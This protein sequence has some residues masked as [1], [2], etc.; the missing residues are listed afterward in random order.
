MSKVAFQRAFQ[1]LSEAEI[2]DVMA[3][4]ERINFP[5]GTHI[6]REGDQNNAIFVVLEGAIRVACFDRGGEEHALGVSLGP[7]DTFGE[8]SFVDGMGASATLIAD[9][10]VLTQVIDRAQIDAMA[11]YRDGFKERI[12]HSLLYT[13]VRRLR[14]M[15]ALLLVQARPSSARR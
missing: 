10:D 6:L 12:Y 7:G 11:A 3:R 4:A 8:M 2:A 5:A 1:E 14:R 15:D 13:V 9:T